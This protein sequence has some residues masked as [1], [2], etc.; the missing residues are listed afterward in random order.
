MDCPPP[1]RTI[2]GAPRKGKKAWEHKELTTNPFPR[3]VRAEDDRRSGSTVEQ[4]SSGSN[5]DRRR[6][7]RFR[8]EEARLGVGEGGG[9]A[10]EGSRVRN[11]GLV[12]GGGKSTE[13]GD[14][15]ASA[16]AP[17]GSGQSEEEEEGMTGGSHIHPDKYL[18]VAWRTVRRP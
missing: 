8:P 11:R 4:A 18:G 16:R 5:G 15:G 17:L 9:G 7:G 6:L 10:G 2:R 3:S 12:A 13:G 1:E 14:D